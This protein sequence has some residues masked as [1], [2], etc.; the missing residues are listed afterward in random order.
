MNSKA[1]INP[2]GEGLSAP[3]IMSELIKTNWSNITEKEFYDV[4]K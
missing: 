4:C 3:A 1:V 2:Y